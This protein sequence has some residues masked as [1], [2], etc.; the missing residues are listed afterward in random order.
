M[1]IVVNSLARAALMLLFLGTFGFLGR[2]SCHGL[3]VTLAWDPSSTTNVASY[4]LYYGS[5]PENYTNTVSVGKATTAT[6]SDL[7]HGATYYFAATVTDT[8]GLES[9]YSTEISYTVPILVVN[10]LPT[11]NA[12]G[13]RAIAQNAPRQTVTLSGVSS[14]AVNEI[15]TL[16][17][18]ATSSNP[19]LIPDPAVSYSNP[20]TTGLL[21]FQPA[22]AAS[23][24]AIITVT[25]ND[26]G[27][28]NNIVSRSFTVTVDEPPAI[29]P[30]PNLV[31]AMNS[32]TA[33]IPFTII[34]THT[35]SSNLTVY[36]TSSNLSLAGASNIFFAGADAN[37]SIIVKPIS[38]QTGTT[39]ITVTVSGPIATASSTFKL[40]VF[41]KPSPPTNMRVASR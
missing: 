12:L 18:T 1:R 2:F 6:L 11:L 33:P 23:G 25:V 37:R 4:T 29:S 39:M 5:S 30:I 38:D 34:D 31:I 22:P 14:G 9:V 19:A 3:T 8:A 36:A 27:L 20:D 40:S 15:Q 7:V 35:A 21:T 41:T 13:D 10:Q 16:S 26:G 32:Q 28:S 24:T 17:V